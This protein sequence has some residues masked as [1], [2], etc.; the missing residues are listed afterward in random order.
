MTNLDRVLKSRDTTLPTTVC[1]VEAL[2]LQ[3]S[4]YR[5]EDWT[6]KKAEHHRVDSWRLVLEKTPESPLDS[7]SLSNQSVSRK[8]NPEY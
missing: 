1:V 4:W 5:S 7:K 8:I 3:W 2:V 6:M